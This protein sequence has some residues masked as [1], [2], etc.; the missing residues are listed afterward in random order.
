MWEKNSS[1]P[2]RRSFEK[3]VRDSRELKNLVDSKTCH[4]GLYFT[5]TLSIFLGGVPSFVGL[6]LLLFFLVWVNNIEEVTRGGGPA[7]G[8]GG[9]NALEDIERI[10]LKDVKFWEVSVYLNV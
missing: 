5:G 6:P 3:C 8:K 7:Q 1:F 2:S 4:T 10:A 9:K